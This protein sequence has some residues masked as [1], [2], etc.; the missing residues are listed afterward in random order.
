MGKDSQALS[1]TLTQQSVTY[2]S[3]KKLFP[4]KHHAHFNTC[5]ASS[6]RS[7]VHNKSMLAT[8]GAYLS[9]IWKHE[10]RT[11]IYIDFLLGRRVYLYKILSITP[12]DERNKFNICIR[13]YQIPA[14]AVDNHL[15]PSTT[16]TPEE[17]YYHH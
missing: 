12:L 6:C 2:D 16:V 9:L 8:L 3:R 1:T 5:S 11:T 14:A 10:H 4:K 17:R 7:D 13:I 15:T